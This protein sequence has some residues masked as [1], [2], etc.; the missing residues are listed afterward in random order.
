M[1]E[2]VLC[3][4]DHDMV[5]ATDM[6]S[7]S[8]VS[9]QVYSPTEFGNER[10]SDQCSQAGG[11]GNALLYDGLSPKNQCINVVSQDSVY[12]AL[13]IQVREFSFRFSGSLWGLH[14]YTTALYLWE[15]KFTVL[16]SIL[17]ASS[18]TLRMGIR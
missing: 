8:L 14:Q 13:L 11:D 7:I 2:N 18:M 10:L 15:C 1:F 9:R 17:K 3:G 5:R 4:V 6:L 16:L 12:N